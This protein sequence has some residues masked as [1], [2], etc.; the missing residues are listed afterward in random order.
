MAAASVHFT[1]NGEQREAPG[2]SRL[3]AVL[4]ELGVDVR[5]IAVERNREVVPRAEHAALVIEDGD[6][7]EIV[8]FVGGG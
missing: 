4:E 2:G 1:V 8:Q 7:F 6:S 5:R 3:L